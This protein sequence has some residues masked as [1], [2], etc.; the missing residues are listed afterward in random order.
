ME[1]EDSGPR[2]GIATQTGPDEAFQDFFRSFQAE[3]G[4]YK[5]RQRLA[6]MSSTNSRSLIVDFED[7]LAFDSSLAKGLVRSPDEYVR[8]ANKAVWLQMRIE[9]PE[10]ADSTERLFARFRR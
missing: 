5:Y 9:D 4:Q 1:K 7:L 6:Q 2:G 3:T 10:Y 8:F